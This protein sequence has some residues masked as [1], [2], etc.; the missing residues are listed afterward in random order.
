MDKASAT[1]ELEFTV[2]TNKGTDL[3]T[4]TFEFIGEGENVII[5]LIIEIQEDLRAENR[6][7]TMTRIHD[8]VVTE[9]ADLDRDGATITIESDCF[10]TYALV[11]V[12]ANIGSNSGGNDSDNDLSNDKVDG[13]AS[14]PGAISP[15]IGEAANYL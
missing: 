15:K 13:G 7:F 10:S 1:Y 2:P 4:L 9:L 3:G 11:Y 14:V 6:E 12:D 8:G 5:R